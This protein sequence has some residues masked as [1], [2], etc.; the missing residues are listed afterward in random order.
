MASSIN[1]RKPSEIFKAQA[2]LY[3]HI[4]AFIDSMSLKWAVEMNIPNIIQ[5]HGKPISLSNLVS[6]LQV[7]SS[8]I[9]NVR[10]LM[11][12]L[13]HNGF[14]EI[15]TKEEESYALTVASE[16]LVRGSDLCLAPMVEC[17]LD[18][19]LSGSYH[20]LKKWIYEEDLTLFGVTLGSG[21]WDFLDKNPEY[22]TSFNDAMASDSKLINLA[23]RDC[24]F[25]FDGLES[26]VDVG[27]GTGTT[28][29][30]ICETF[31]KLKCIVFDRPQVVENLSGSNNLTYVGGDMFTS[32]PNAD[33]VL[34]KYILHNWTDKDCLRILKKCKEAVTNDGKRGK[35]TIIDMVIDEKK[36]EN[37]V[38]QIKLLMDVNM[39]CLNGKERNE[40]EWKKLF[41]EAG[42]QHYKI[43]PL[44]GFL[45]LIEIYP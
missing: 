26:I 1:G 22:N 23:L 25:V 14:F 28:A 37:Q 9:G 45:S 10:R 11:R 43:S 38:T 15:I 12:Y 8:K 16:L 30:I 21:F 29:K 44:T 24:D 18:P 34:L 41:I 6:I 31:P 33:A 17:V 32:I 7:P 4:Y 40:E 27:G 2:L 42:F 39:A 19:T 3:K 13:A 35:V 5:N 20:E 36:D